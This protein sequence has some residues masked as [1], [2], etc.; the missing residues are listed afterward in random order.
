MRVDADRDRGSMVQCPTRV[1][2]MGGHEQSRIGSEVGGR[3]T[4]RASSLIAADDR[5]LDLGWAAE[6]TRRRRHVALPEE[7]P[8]SRRRNALDERDL[9]DLQAALAKKGDVTTSSLSEPEAL[10][11]DHDSRAERLENLG[12]ELLGLAAR[13]LL[14]ELEDD[15]I[16]GPDRIDQL[17]SALEA[18]D[19]LHVVA[20]HR[21]RMWRERH[22][23]G[24]QAGRDG[25]LDRG[26]VAPVDTVEGADRDRSLGGLELRG[27]PDDLHGS[28]VS[29]RMK[30]SPARPTATSSPFPR[31][32][33]TGPSPSPARRLPLRR[34][35]ASSSVT[36]RSAM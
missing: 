14:R 21:A 36:S 3:E 20:E 23:G 24:T 34:R 1:D 15:E 8:D 7:L 13:E 18:R 16:V 28:T 5:P 17:D 19:E 33:A 6:Q 22:D 35:R 10:G 26:A 32:R 11:G 4:E 29:G 2:P 31:Q 9:L 27:R 12:D 25:R 30:P